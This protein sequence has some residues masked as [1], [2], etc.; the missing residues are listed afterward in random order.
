MI[1]DRVMGLDAAIGVAASRGHFQLNVYKP[2]GNSPGA[3]P[4]GAALYLGR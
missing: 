4:S 1:C 3:K 2:P